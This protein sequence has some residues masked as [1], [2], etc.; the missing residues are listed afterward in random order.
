MNYVRKL[1]KFN[2]DKR[3]VTALEYGMIA[4][5]IAAVCIGGFSTVGGTLSSKLSVINY[6]MTNP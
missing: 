1:L 5:L 4:A 2:S 6:S 3:A